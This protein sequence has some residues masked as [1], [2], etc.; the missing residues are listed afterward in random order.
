M[1]Q[2]GRGAPW[3]LAMAGRVIHW[4]IRTHAQI[5]I[6]AASGYLAVVIASVLIKG[7]HQLSAFTLVVAAIW[8]IAGALGQSRH[9]ERRRNGS[10]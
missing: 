3:L 6:L 2:D 10:A 7:W 9:L 1:R 8:L 5:W 4:R